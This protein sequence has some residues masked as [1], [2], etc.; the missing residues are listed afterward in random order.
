MAE[1]IGIWVGGLVAGSM[2]KGV[3][4]MVLLDPDRYREIPLD[5]DY[6]SWRT[7]ARRNL[8]DTVRTAYP[9]CHQYQHSLQDMEH[10]SGRRE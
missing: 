7:Q 8:Q 2:G 10:I 1:T 4:H 5:T 3:G 9:G 6:N